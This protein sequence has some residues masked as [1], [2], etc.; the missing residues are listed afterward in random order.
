MDTK[1]TWRS[2]GLQGSRQPRCSWAWA[3]GPCHRA[4]CPESDPPAGK[5]GVFTEGPERGDLGRLSVW[6]GRERFSGPIGGGSPYRRGS[7]TRECRRPELGDERTEHSARPEGDAE[8]CRE[9]DSPAAVCPEA[10]G[11]S[12][13]RTRLDRRAGVTV[14]K[15]GCRDRSRV[16]LC[17][18]VTQRLCWGLCA[19]GPH[20]PGLLRL[21]HTAQRVGEPRPGR[22]SS[23]TTAPAGPALCPGQAAPH[24]APHSRPRRARVFIPE[25]R[26]PP[27]SRTRT[28]RAVDGCRSPCGRVWVLGPARP[29]ATLPRAS[30]HSA[31]GETLPC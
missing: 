9:A 21:P 8:R 24:A 23:R 20:P 6:A 29:P 31:A 28:G 13:L 5:L 10:P 15:R 3:P 11:G 26:E 16:G 7:Q 14:L 22:G 4:T 17:H 18:T 25:K 27:A 2:L 30:S 1:T 19:P 12:V